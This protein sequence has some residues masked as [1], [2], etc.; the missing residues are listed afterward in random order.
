M[1][2]ARRHCEFRGIDDL[3]GIAIERRR[4]RGDA[5]RGK[6]DV[7]DAGRAA[8]AVDNGAATDQ[9]IPAH[10]MLGATMPFAPVGRL[11]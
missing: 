3:V 2:E 8:A 10:R 9:N 4:E 5:A 6:G 1:G 7:S 11:V